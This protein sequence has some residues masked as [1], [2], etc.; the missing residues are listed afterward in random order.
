M[1]EP[2]DS[3]P[4]TP[5]EH[6]RLHFYAGVIALRSELPP[7]LQVQALEPYE[8]GIEAAGGGDPAR[9]AAE[10]DAWEQDTRDRLPL[11]DLRE[12]GGLQH[13]DLVLL[14]LIG[15]AEEDPRFSELFEQLQGSG[16]PRPTLGLLK[17]LSRR[18]DVRPSL[19]RLRALGLVDVVNA[20]EP[21]LEW[22]LTVAPAVWDALR[23][24]ADPELGTWARVRGP[25][26][27]PLAADLILSPELAQTLERA[28]QALAGAD[29]RTL[30]VRGRESSGRR[31]VAAAVAR[32]MGRGAIEVSGPP[33]AHWSVL[34][35][36]A[37]L[38]DAMPIA[39]IELGPGETVDLP[40][41][42]GYD[43]PRAVAL[44]L[45]G[46][47]T[48]AVDGALT[49]TLGLPAASERWRHWA[50]AIG[51]PPSDQ[52][53]VQYR[54]TAG[55]I[56]RT[57]ALARA[58]AALAGRLVPAV[59]DVQ[60][61]A[62]AL[63]G[64]LLDSLAERLPPADRWEG[65]A[66]RAETARELELLERRCVERER[67]AQTGGPALCGQLGT[68]VR[69][70]FTGP[71][72][73][74]KTLAARV[75]AGRVAL[76][77]YRLNLA[78]VVNKYL[79]ETEKNLERAFAH[80]EGANA[81]LLLDEG[82]ALLTQRTSVQ[83]AND[84]YANLETNYLLQRLET[85]EGI[86]L[87]TTNAG[88]RIDSAFRRRM[89]VIIDFRAPEPLERLR[90]LDLHLP[91]DHFVD[92]DTLETIAIRCD[93]TGGQLR[94]AVLHAELLGLEAGEPV[95]PP[96]LE[97]AVRREYRKTGAMCPLPEPAGTVRG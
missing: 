87:V 49:V 33:D 61:A 93:L 29:A 44:G 17:A 42:A 69:A 75:L 74:G 51:S 82:D 85:F 31:T 23:G 62:R 59:D 16:H 97:E 88:D 5:A 77:A 14:F 73:T 92:Q 76:D 94:N 86:L 67:L 22:A 91:P 41:L 47:V 24:E 60:L 52:V 65:L 7:E 20:G 66:V 50:E 79:G 4:H 57:A 10:I 9:W 78:A 30:I 95:D 38:L 39:T 56:R 55:N 89:D 37:T 68:G 34:G 90:I 46:G 43:G 19:R 3:L 26:E 35:S 8:A 48:G 84:R 80:A 70:L 36:L 32:A 25:Q 1:V 18:I 54:M 27:L 11:R 45:H 83:T 15:L 2:F 12:A 40:A 81:V 64:Q 96:M 71:S 6:F 63:Q 21:R 72:G 28:P 58:Q 53:V 13:G